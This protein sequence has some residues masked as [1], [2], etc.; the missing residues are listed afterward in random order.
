VDRITAIL[1]FQWRAYWRRFRGSASLRADNAGVLV[2]FGSLASLRFFQQLPLVASQLGRGQTAR[3]ETLLN[4]VF[5]AWMV[6][7]MGESKPSIASRSLL[8]FPLTSVELFL[9]RVGGVFCSPLSWVV[10]ALSFA[11]GYPVAVSE[12]PVTGLIG[13]L[14]LLLLG[15]FTSLTITHLLQ[16]A[17][18]RRLSLVAVLSASVVAGLLWLQKQTQFASALRSLLPHRLAVAA[19]TS[20]TPVRSVLVLLALTAFFA[21]L[22]S[23]TFKLTLHSQQT[24]RSQRVF[25]LTQL[26]GK[27]GGLLK[28]DLRY[29]SRL[30]DLYLVLPIAVLFNMYLA[31]DAAP[32]ELGFAIIIAVLFL[33]CVSIAF[34][35]FGLDSALALD[36]YTLFPLSGKEKLFSKNLGFAVMMFVLLATMLPLAFWRLG[37]R[38]TVL[39]FMEFVAVGLAY[40]FCGNWLSVKQPF[41]M[42]FYRFASGGSLVDAMIGI[43]VA[44]APAAFTVYL[45]ASGD[46]GTTWKLAAVTLLCLVLYLLSLARSARVLE[47][48]H[49]LIRRVL[50]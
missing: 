20:S 10:V 12:H 19:A 47:N 37:S 8:H 1:K 18:A 39:G 5:L 24:R 41:R 2:L 23:W 17:L 7:V 40:M 42:Q 9:I 22:A 26:P 50:S 6:P 36:R 49:E 14:A 15:L 32:S 3:Y 46:A 16:G 21:V 33:P 11:L 25:G 45:F 29:S 43:M 48:Q 35:C 28:K 4:V 38:V 13:L 27:F 34:N 30:L 44:S 31:S